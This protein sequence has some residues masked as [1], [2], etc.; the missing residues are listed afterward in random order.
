MI[1][2]QRAWNAYTAD[3]TEK[4]LLA[5]DINRTTSPQKRFQITTESISTILNTRRPFTRIF[6]AETKEAAYEVFKK[7]MADRQLHEDKTKT[8]IVE[9]ANEGETV[10]KEA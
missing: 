2:I 8:T 6:Y 5:G 3:P 7:W 1:E 10:R 9:L 4:I